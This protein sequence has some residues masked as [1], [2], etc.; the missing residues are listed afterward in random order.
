MTMKRVLILCTGNSAR[1]QMAEGLLRC[2]AG[3]R[4]EAFSAGT[5]AAGLNP[6][7]VTA[8]AE[9]GVDIFGHRSKAVDEFEGQEFDYYHG[10]RQRETVMPDTS[11]RG[12]AYSS[13]FQPGSSFGYFASFGMKCPLREFVW[14]TASVKT[15]VEVKLAGWLSAGRSRISHSQHIPDVGCHGRV[16]KNGIPQIGSVR[17]CRDCK[18]KQ[19]DHLFRVWAKQVGAKYSISLIFDQDLET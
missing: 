8:M 11:G 2:M 13:Q 9:I 4:F 19:V 10:M 6:N 14:D 3:D 12:Q 18:R 16:R 7:A 1:S 5:C 15:N 17:V